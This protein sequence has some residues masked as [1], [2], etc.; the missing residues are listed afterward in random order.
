MQ[1][2]HEKPQNARTTP[3]ATT[4]ENPV[5]GGRAELAIVTGGTRGIGAALSARLIKLGYRV[6]AVYRTSGG[7]ADGTGALP[8]Q[9]DISD[10]QAVA[11]FADQVLDEH[12]TPAVLVNNA[13]INIDRPFLE[14]TGADWQRVIDT[15]LSGPF[16]L[17]KAFAPAMLAAG[18][19]NIVNIGATTGI[20]PRSNGVNYAASKAGL[21]QLT[22]CLATELAP[23][24]RV[25]CLIPGMTETDEL[26]T[27][28]RL[29]DPEHRAAVLAEIPQR[30]IGSPDDIAD[31]LEFL[32]SAHS[33]YLTG[34]KLIV[35]GGQFMW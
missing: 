23:A 11:A 30:R 17:I 9:C 26:I 33:S 16:H 22:K 7:A 25:N 5:A 21:L 28:F 29:D 3:S 35:D 2:S 8:V 4:A 24:I 20:R 15:N 27:R 19:G 1:P 12:G 34:Q 31:A 6:I 18:A 32:V 10:P 13:G 14:L